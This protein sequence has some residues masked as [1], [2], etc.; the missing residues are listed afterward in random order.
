MMDYWMSTKSP[1]EIFRPAGLTVEIEA[2]LRELDGICSAI[3]AADLG[4]PEGLVQA[5][6]RRLGLRA[7][8]MTCSSGRRYP[9]SMRGH[10]SKIK[11]PEGLLRRRIN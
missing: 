10:N 11:T 6:Q 9:V 3:I 5:Y 2:K 8:S 4:L 1:R 7:I